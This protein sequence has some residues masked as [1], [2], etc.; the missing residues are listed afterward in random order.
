VP[1]VS[2]SRVLGEPGKTVVASFND[3]TIPARTWP[4]KDGHISVI[5]I[6]G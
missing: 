6:T 2:T 4:A 5:E 3:E 1:T